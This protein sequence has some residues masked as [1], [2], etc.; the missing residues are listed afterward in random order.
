MIFVMEMLTDIPNWWEKVNAQMSSFN[1]NVVTQAYPLD[2]RARHRGGVE[3][4]GL[5]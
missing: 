5:E 2:I 3:K 4:H 1:E